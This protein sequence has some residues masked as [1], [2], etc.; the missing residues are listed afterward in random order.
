MKFNNAK[1]RIKVKLGFDNIEIPS[2][3]NYPPY[4]S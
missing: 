4:F 3:E 2:L 1:T